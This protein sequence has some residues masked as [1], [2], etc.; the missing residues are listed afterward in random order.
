MQFTELQIERQ[1]SANIEHE[2]SRTEG[3]LQSALEANEELRDALASALPFVEDAINDPAYKAGYVSLL[4]KA[5]RK[6]I[7]G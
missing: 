6:T 2:L 7:E 3:E 1:R 5:I 4:A